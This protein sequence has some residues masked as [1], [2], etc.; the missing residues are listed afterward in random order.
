VT[1]VGVFVR[2]RAASVLKQ[3][4]GLLTEGR[5]F[6]TKNSGSLIIIPE[7]ETKLVQIEILRNTIL[8]PKK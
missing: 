4:H 2:F 1:V 6:N 8:F 3:L 7:D 5:C